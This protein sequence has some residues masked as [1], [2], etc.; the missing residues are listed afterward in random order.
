[1]TAGSMCPCSI[2][3]QFLLRTI[4][5]PYLNAT[6]RRPNE[7]QKSLTRGPLDFQAVQKFLSITIERRSQLI[8]LGFVRVV[9]SKVLTLSAALAPSKKSQFALLEKKI[10]FYA[11]LDRR[12]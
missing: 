12:P 11:I 6:M 5:F 9:A 4:L 1:M 10:E 8:I 3:V 7:A 2:T